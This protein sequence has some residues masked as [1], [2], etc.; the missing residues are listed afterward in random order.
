MRS[1]EVAP[2]TSTVSSTSLTMP[3][4]APGA[5]RETVT[6]ASGASGSSGSDSTTSKPDDPS[7]SPSPS[8]AGGGAKSKCT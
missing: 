1:T 6:V 5:G 2:V 4:R 8:L 3:K 7:A